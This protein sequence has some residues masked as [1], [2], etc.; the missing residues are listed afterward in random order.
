M[1]SLEEGC[2]GEGGTGVSRLFLFWRGGEMGKLTEHFC[3][4]ELGVEGADP[5]L[6]RNAK[7][8]C[9]KILEPLRYRFGPLY[10]HCGYRAPEHNA[11]VGGKP[12]SW[13]LFEG[14]KAAADFHIVGKD[15]EDLFDFIRFFSKLPFDKVILERSGGVARCVHVQ[16]DCEAEP[17]RE[18][19]M[20]STGA[21]TVYEGVAGGFG[22]E[23]TA[24]E[25]MAP[26]G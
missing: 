26:K 25:A 1:T 24:K 7:A 15:T 23:G 8:L 9:E 18:A 11:A 21:G 13:H 17:R 22:V 14:G 4:L 12:N 2:V 20:G 5:R 10:V 19:Y 6:K 16:F 3:E